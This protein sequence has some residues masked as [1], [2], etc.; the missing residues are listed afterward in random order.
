MAYSRLQ[1][2]ILAVA[3]VRKM[4]ELVGA[5]AADTHAR[6]GKGPCQLAQMAIAA[7][8]SSSDAEPPAPLDVTRPDSRM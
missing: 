7:R 8:T 2:A 1:R 6:R 4:P 3:S 5:P